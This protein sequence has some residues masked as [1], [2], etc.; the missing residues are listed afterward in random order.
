LWEPQTS[1]SRIQSDDCDRICY[2]SDDCECDTMRP[3]VSSLL[4]PAR[5]VA[6]VFVMAQVIGCGSSTS[7]QQAGSSLIILPEPASESVPL[8]DTAT[9]SVGAMGDGSLNY[10]WSENGTEIS[11]ATS[12]TYTTPA[13]AIQ[14]SGE[15]FTVTVR[16]AGSSVTSSPAILTVGPRSP[17][18]GDLRFQQVDAPSESDQGAGTTSGVLANNI[19]TYD[20]STGSPLAIGDDGSC[21]PNSSFVDCVWA[22]FHTLLP[23]GQSGLNANYQSGEYTAFDSEIGSIQSSDSVIT[24]LDFVPAYN[25]YAI[26]WMQTVT[27]GGFDIRHEVVSPSAAAATV[28]QDASESR[29][30][31]AVSFDANGHANLISYG[32]QGDTTTLY[33]TQVI[34]AAPQDVGADATQLAGEGYILTAFGGDTT[35]GFLLIGTK[36]MGDTLARPIIVTDQ[37]SSPLAHGASAGYAPVLW[38]NYLA[39]NGTLEGWD[40]IYQ[41]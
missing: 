5:F 11:G 1:A 30:V 38:L 2:R 20:N 8:G 16:D 10:Q 14:D 24:S 15:I 39:P 34:A 19:V 32:W 29:V 25:V 37:S 35:N 21:V 17:K 41:K 3:A 13:V 31:T 22:E 27:S 7:L 4:Y 36:V 6:V 33:D 18:V 12:A 40:V 9:F 26:A 23:S 28:A